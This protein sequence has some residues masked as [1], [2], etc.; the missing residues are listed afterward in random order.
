MG[1]V[2][3]GAVLAAATVVALVVLGWI[4]RHRRDLGTPADRATFATLHTA[5]LAAPALRAGL[6]PVSAERA[7]RHLRTLLGAPAVALTD[8]TGLLAWDGGGTHHREQVVGLAAG[9]MDAG[10]SQVHGPSEVGCARPACDLRA[11]VVAPLSVEDRVVGAVV[12]LSETTSAG[13]VRATRT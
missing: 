7:V 13:L 3:A 4:W 2:G 11:A 9:A 8:T 5:S 6:T 12:A 10:D 1:E